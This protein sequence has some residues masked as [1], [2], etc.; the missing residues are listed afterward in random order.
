MSD[1]L[2]NL[3]YNF[4]LY[5][6]KMNE[7]KFYGQFTPPLDKV[8]YER[9]FSSLHNGTSIE[10]GAFDGITENTTYFF[11]KNMN[12]NTINIEPLPYMYEKLTSI[13]NT[14]R[15]INLNI[16]LSD[17][18]GNATITVYDLHHYGINNTNASLCH[19]ENH[20]K[21]LENM[22]YGKKEFTIQTK[23]YSTV[24]DELKIKKL[25]LFV[26]DVEGFEENVLRG[27]IGCAIIPKIFVIEHGHR[28][29]SYFDDM[30]K[31]IH[32]K[33]RLDHVSFVNSIY[34]LDD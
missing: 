34:V 30:I 20:R 32:K 25:D 14:N 33:Y 1:L 12:W 24:I 23:T 17:T 29:I 4:K 8:L 16:A 2:P 19:T 31:N 6:Y 9:Y 27:M 21:A 13:R 5:V 22:S 3:D 11:Q 7:L 26:L 15:D 10:A 18:N 28:H